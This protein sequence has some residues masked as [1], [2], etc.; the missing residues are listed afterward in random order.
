VSLNQSHPLTDDTN[1]AATFDGTND[2][3]SAPLNLSTT[4]KLTIEFWMRWNTV[5]YTN[6]DD[7][8]LELTSNFNNTN[9]G[10]LINPA[11]STS[12]SRFEV[13][14]GRGTSR[15]SI[16]FTRPSVL[17]W[18]HYAFV[19]DTTAAASQQILAYVDGKAVAVTKGSSG[20]GAG[21]FANSTL[22][23]MSRG[24]TTQFA[25]ATL[26][27]VAI[28]KAALTATQIAQHYAAR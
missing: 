7:Q 22:Y 2:Y 20:T 6:N 16:Y 21:A 3:A 26:D 28:Y 8:A 12:S 23:F 13:A 17:A 4:S 11:S 9:G 1:A 5:L 24:G 15:N 18:H 25:P 27:E 14:I 19:I 10:F